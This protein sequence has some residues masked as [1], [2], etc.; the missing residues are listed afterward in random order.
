MKIRRSDRFFTST[1]VPD[2]TPEQMQWWNDLQRITTSPENAVRI[3][4]A[5]SEC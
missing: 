3:M 2:G 4:Q 5:I 1:F